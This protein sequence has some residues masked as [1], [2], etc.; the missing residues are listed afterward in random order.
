MEIKILKITSE[1]FALPHFQ[2]LLRSKNDLKSPNSITGFCMI[3]AL[4]HLSF[5]YSLSACWH[6]FHHEIVSGGDFLIFAGK[7]WKPQATNG[8]H[9]PWAFSKSKSEGIAP[10]RGPMFI[11]HLLLTCS[12]PVGK[13]SS[14]QSK[15]LPSLHRKAHLLSPYCQPE[16]P[17]ESFREWIRLSR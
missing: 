10:Q 6:C 16:T 9:V 4:T 15:Q 2:L 3:G 11:S 14:R 7:S 5:N 1:N 17:P 8:P 12:V 13:D